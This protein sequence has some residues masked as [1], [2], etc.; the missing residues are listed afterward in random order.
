MTSWETPDVITSYSIHYTK[1]YDR[2]VAR[3]LVDGLALRIDDAEPSSE[4]P[5]RSAVRRKELSI[6]ITSYNVCYTKLLR[7]RPRSAV[8]A[9]RMPTGMRRLNRKRLTGVV[10]MMRTRTLAAMF[11]HTRGG[12][13]MRC[14]PISRMSRNNF[15]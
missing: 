11:S 5:G 4:Q 9:Y 2:A 14:G 8:P 10:S 3:A 6:R 12:E 1:L 7:F 13:K 15:V